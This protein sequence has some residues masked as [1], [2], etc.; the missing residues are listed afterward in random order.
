MDINDIN[1]LTGKFDLVYSS[2][3]FHY[4]QDFS[5]LVR[6]IYQKL[7]DGGKLLYSQEHPINTATEGV[8][9]FDEKGRAL[10]YTFS[11]YGRGGKRE[12][13]WFVNGVEKYHRPMGEI[14]T[15]IANAGFT[16][17]KLVEPLPDKTALAMSSS[18]AKESI[19]PSFL[20]IRAR[21]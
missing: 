19:R 8:F 4:I 10:S 11:D 1:Q 5:A 3:A 9:N 16:I 13:T 6:N 18:L 17:E 20:L 7:N 2:L 14:V 12:V 21:K 15:E